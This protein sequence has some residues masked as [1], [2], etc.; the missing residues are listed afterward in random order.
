MIRAFISTWQLVGDQV[1]NPI[2]DY[3]DTLP[4][5]QTV[6]ERI[7]CSMHYPDADANGLPDKNRVLV[8]VEG[9]ITIEGLAQL[10]GVKMLPAYRFRK[11]IGEIPAA[12]RHAIK[13]QLQAEG[14][15]L[16]ALSGIRVYGDFLRAVARYFNTSHSGFGRHIEI[17]REAEFG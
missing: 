4:P 6:A 12:V 13:T 9:P 10:P 15:P 2:V 14:I 11:P 5:A 1:T 16:S 17:N 7:I 3:V 8:I